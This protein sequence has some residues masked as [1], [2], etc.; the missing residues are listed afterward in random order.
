M[1][2]TIVVNVSRRVPHPRY[3]KVIKKNKKYYTDTAGLSFKEGQ[4]V[5]IIE[6]RPLSKTK[7]WR[8]LDD[9]LSHLKE[10]SI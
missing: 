1:E 6:T 3:H 5:T 7:R 8:V 4:E 2:G 10:A 9:S